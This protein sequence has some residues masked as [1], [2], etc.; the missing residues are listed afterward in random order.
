MLTIKI[1][2]A[3]GQHLETPNVQIP[4]SMIHSLGTNTKILILDLI[5]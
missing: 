4:E 5:A 1:T 2:R 3:H